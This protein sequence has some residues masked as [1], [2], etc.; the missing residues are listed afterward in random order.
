MYLTKYVSV[1]EVCTLYHWSGFMALAPS[2]ISSI[3][4]VKLY[5]PL[6]VAAMFYVEH[7]LPRIRYKALC[8]S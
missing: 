4:T 3:T 7:V 2:L 8:L 1:A 6:V 5:V